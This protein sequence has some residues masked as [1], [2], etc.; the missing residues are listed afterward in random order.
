MFT[1]YRV[2][3]SYRDAHGDII[4]FGCI[5]DTKEEAIKQQQRY[6]AEDNVRSVSID[7]VTRG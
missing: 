1:Y 6:A 3:A 2:T 5:C 4:G 7:K